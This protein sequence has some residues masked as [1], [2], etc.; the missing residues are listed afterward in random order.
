MG[1]SR[2]GC[3]SLPC[4]PCPQGRPPLPPDLRIT[5]D[6]LRTTLDDLRTTL[7]D[8]RT[9]LDDLRITLDDLRTTLDDLRVSLTD[10]RVPDRP[11]DCPADPGLFGAAPSPQANLLSWQS[12]VQAMD[13][14]RHFL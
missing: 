9:T 6:D 5:L 8:L 3:V 1:F 10:L 12:Q 4:L 7:D 11:R 14:V 13:P 2:R